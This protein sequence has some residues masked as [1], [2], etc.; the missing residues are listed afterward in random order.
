MPGFNEIP[1]QLEARVIRALCGLLLVL[2]W[3]TMAHAQPN[4]VPFKRITPE[5][6]LSQS[7]VYAI[8]QDRRGFMWFGT[9]DGLNRYDGY[10]FSVFQHDPVLRAAQNPKPK[11]PLRPIRMNRQRGCIMYNNGTP[12]T[13]HKRSDCR[14]N[15]AD[16]RGFICSMIRILFIKG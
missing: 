13:P 12:M 14:S 16:D 6:E 2:G 10:R 15:R 5:D 4:T 11:Q 1:K 9:Q 7:T 8:A 3:A